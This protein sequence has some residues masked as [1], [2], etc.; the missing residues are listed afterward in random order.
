MGKIYQLSILY[1]LRSACW[2]LPWSS[3]I[4][5]PPSDAWTRTDQD[6]STP[7]PP[8]PR[9]SARSEAAPTLPGRRLW[10]TTGS[11]TCA[12]PGSPA[13]TATPA[14]WPPPPTRRSPTRGR[15]P[16]ER[17]T[18]RCDLAATEGRAFRARRRAGHSRISSRNQG[19]K[20]IVV[21]NYAKR[22]I[23]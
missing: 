21:V 6:R 22:S 2:S 13:C 19:N 23:Y 12:A 14:P 11:C 8:C 15:S 9:Q 7:R 18:E 16:P 10:D 4:C 5:L 1:L 20:K 3:W 17:R